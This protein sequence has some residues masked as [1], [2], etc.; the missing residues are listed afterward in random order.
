MLTSIG[1][2]RQKFQPI[3]CIVPPYISD[4][5]MVSRNKKTAR[6]AAAN[7]L[8]STM[9]RAQRE[10]I[11]GLSSEQMMAFA[12]K[13]KAKKKAKLN[14]QVFDMKHGT[15][16]A[17]ATLV[18]NNGKAIKSLDSDSKNVISAGTATWNLYYE[19]FHRNSLDNLGLLMRHYIHYY[20]Q[21][22]NAM[23]DGSEMVY[24]DGDGTIFDSFT[25]D[26]D[27][28][29]HELTH[30]VTQYESNLDYHNQSGALNES[31]SD[32][33]GIMVK[34]RLLNEDVKQSHWLIGE[35]VLIGK[36]Y[37]LRSLKAPGTAFVNHPDLGTDPQPAT[38]DEYVDLPDTKKGDWGGV[39]TN[40]GITN[41]AFYVSAFNIGG[42]SWEKAGR[43][44]YDAM[45]DR[46][47][48]RSE[49]TFADFKQLTIQKAER[50][51]GVG[52][53]EAR[54]VQQG[55]ETAKV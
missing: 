20:K 36:K 53:L 45:T 16:T 10:F 38:L 43:I 6:I 42:F 32:I 4:R 34:Q 51:F 22:D 11:N 17:D 29:G 49:A 5:L 47:N 18:W 26:A 3:Q 44:W 39:H 15:N 8:Q 41:Y 30:G 40:S 7:H 23:W 27:I 28:I 9:L 21:Y 35:N 1:I 12:P 31:L 2:Q 48:F 55:W 13:A 33:F 14:M 50:L 37:A 46:N 24:G 25:S 52:S 19:I 54:A